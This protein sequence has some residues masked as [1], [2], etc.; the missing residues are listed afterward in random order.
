MREDSYRRGA[1]LPI[2]RSLLPDLQIQRVMGEPELLLRRLVWALALERPKLL[3]TRRP[4][5]AA[6]DAAGEEAGSG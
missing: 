6:P 3:A 4:R 1:D 2:R 5:A